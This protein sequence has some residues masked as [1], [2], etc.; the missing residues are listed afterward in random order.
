[1]VTYLIHL[2]VCTSVNLLLCFSVNAADCPYQGPDKGM[3][4]DPSTVPRGVRA[5][6]SVR[7]NAN[8]CA[9]IKQPVLP[10]GADDIAS[11][12]KEISLEPK[13][14]GSGIGEGGISTLDREVELV[15]DQ[16]RR[17]FRTLFNL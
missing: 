9:P 5:I 17:N 8:I 4:N 7:L 14:A 1:M 2:S 12:L 11:S 6:A 3:R 10:E 16:I 13:A 15:R